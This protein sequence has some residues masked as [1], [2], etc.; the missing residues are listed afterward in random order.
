MADFYDTDRAVAE[1][2]LFHY[3]DDDLRMP[4]AFGPRDGA[5][6]PARC[7]SECLLR[8]AIPVRA[9]ALDLGCAVGRASFEL[10]RFCTE[11]VGI[12]LSRPFIEAADR[13]RREGSLRFPVTLEGRSSTEAL[14]RIPSGSDPARVRF[15]T[16]DA[17]NLRPDLGHFDVVL[18]A[19]LLDRVPRPRE[20]L[21]AFS[22]LV[23]SG[24]QLVLTSP[25]T[26]LAEYT[27]PDE[28]LG[29]AARTTSQALPGL[30]SDFRLVR[31][32]DLPLVIRE[33]ARKFQW[34]VAEATTWIRT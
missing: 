1:Y 30:L 12:D 34:S 6:F 22:D 24:G 21:R 9:R 28:W 4:W 18:A 7:V 25:Y 8:E 29:Q 17:L 33:H 16:G 2:L 3:G 20:L 32:L 14:A 5:A 26:W 10:S 11:V 31:R 15:E 23:R 19:N 27:P 13:L